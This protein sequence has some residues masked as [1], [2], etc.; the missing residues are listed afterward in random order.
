[1]SLK[2]VIEI[3]LS[4]AQ[5]L[6]GENF[7]KHI[8]ELAGASE[9][10]CFNIF[11]KFA[12]ECP[13]AVLAVLFRLGHFSV[14]RELLI[15]AGEVIESRYYFGSEKENDTAG[16]IEYLLLHFHRVLRGE[17]NNGKFLFFITTNYK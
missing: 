1:M 5:S 12:G 16:H 11:G 8:C 13:S 6:C 9:E 17:D 2:K 4:L 3:C 10:K 14:F 15:I 7:S